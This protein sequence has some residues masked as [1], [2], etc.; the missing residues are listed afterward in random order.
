MTIR[1]DLPEPRVAPLPRNLLDA[2]QAGGVDPLVLAA[3]LGL[4]PD[5]LASGLTALEADRF[6]CAAWDA[7]ADPAIGLKAGSLL[8]PERFGVVGIAAMSSPTFGVAVQRKARYWQLIWGDTY[9]VQLTGQEAA[10]VLMPVGPPRPYTQAK[11]DMELASLLAFGRRFTGRPIQPLRLTL[12]QRAPA[13]QQR[14]S[15]TFGCAVQFGGP[16]NALVFSRADFDLPLVSHNAQVEA[17]MASG[18]EAALTRLETPRLQQHVGLVIDRMLQG[19]E[20]TLQAVAQRMHR[21]A[22]TLQR[23]LAQEQLRFTDL[24][25]ERR[26]VAAE[27]YI[28]LGNA[29]AEEVGFL[30]GFSTS[31]SF[32]R[33]FKRWTGHSPQAWRR[34]QA[35][36]G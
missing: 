15:D 18:V 11:I 2:L 16:E 22:R 4:A 6:F 23:Q 28:G 36:A 17:L 31:S 34:L 8:R 14:Y 27:R 10:A 25:D 20:P 33:A 21:S 24:L 7:V 29:T 26:R 1:R 3:R 35:A 13:W 12:C 9:R 19:D 5:A 30:L 32:F